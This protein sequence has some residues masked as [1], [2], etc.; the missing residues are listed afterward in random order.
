[1]PFRLGDVI[2]FGFFALLIHFIFRRSPRAKD[3]SRVSPI[4]RDDAP[5]A[6]VVEVASD[7][8][9]DVPSASAEEVAVSAGVPTGRKV[10]VAGR[11]ALFQC[12]EYRCGEQYET[13]VHRID[14]S[15]KQLSQPWA[16]REPFEKVMESFT[17]VAGW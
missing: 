7:S 6:S 4:A 16:Y 9:R 14:Q 1:M 10:N 11:G 13:R 12:V 15:G 3:A 2:L 8:E 5:V 17:V